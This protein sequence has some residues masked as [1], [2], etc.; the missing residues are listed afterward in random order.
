MAASH[1]SFPGS[2]PLFQTIAQL[3]RSFP[4]QLTADTL[5]RLGLAPANESR[6]LGVLKFLGIID[7]SGN[8]TDAAKRIFAVHDDAE[9][10]NAL[11]DLVRNA[12][13]DLFDLHGEASWTLDQG[14]LISYFRQAD[15]T[16]ALVGQRQATTFQVL[17]SIAGFSEGAPKKSEVEART[18]RP[19]VKRPAEQEQKSTRDSDGGSDAPVNPSLPN[20]RDFGLTVRIEINLPAGGDQ[21]TYDRIFRS[22]RENLINVG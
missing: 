22:I 6:I 4:A 20:K 15:Q 14:K 2:G 16:S 17:A 21:Q 3:R 7:D 5:K 1:P 8:R 10:S 12:Y 18:R 19:R 9:F 11:G 13:K